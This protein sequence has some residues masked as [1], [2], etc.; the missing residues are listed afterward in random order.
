MDGAGRPPTSHCR[1]RQYGCAIERKGVRA[2]LRI[3]I[4]QTDSLSSVQVAVD[5]LLGDYGQFHVVIASMVAHP[6]KGILDLKPT[7]PD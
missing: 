1:K 3:G 5:D 6:G 2:T 7:S 4:G